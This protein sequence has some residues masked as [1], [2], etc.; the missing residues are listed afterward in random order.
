MNITDRFCSTNTWRPSLF[1]LQYHSIQ[2][3]MHSAGKRFFKN[4]DGLFEV[5]KLKAE[6]TMLMQ[7]RG[8]RFLLIYLL[9]FVGI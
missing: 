8:I 7:E 5:G 2:I 3:I 6:I 9:G 1:C 4:V